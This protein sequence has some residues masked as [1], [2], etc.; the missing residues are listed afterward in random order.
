MYASNTYVYTHMFNDKKKT[1]TDVFGGAICRIADM[2][3]SLTERSEVTP[4][5]SQ[6]KTEVEKDL[7]RL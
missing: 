7:A 4:R 2:N 1:V 5:G 3:N 6:I